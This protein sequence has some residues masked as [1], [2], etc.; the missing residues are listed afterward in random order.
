MTGIAHQIRATPGIARQA[1]GQVLPG[2]L[3]LRDGTP[4]LIWPLLPTD[5]GTLRDVFRRLSPDSRHQRFLQVL[6][7]LDDPM[8]WRLVDSVDGVHHIALLLI[9]L[10]PEGKEEP[11]GVARLV[12]HPE[13]PATADIAI[14]VADDWQR[15]GV[16]TALISALMERR[17]AAVTRLH[18]VIEAGNRGSLAL[19]ARTGQ[20][21]PGLPERGVLDV[22]V[23]LP[24][25]SQARTAAET[26]AWLWAQGTRKIIDQTH[27]LPWL[28]PTSLI[29]AVEGYVEF[30]QR[31]AA[32][33]GD[34]AV[35][36]AEAASAQF[37][38]VC[39]QVPH[40]AGRR[41]R[42]RAVQHPRPGRCA[43][44]TRP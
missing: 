4:V 1:P 22:T 20:M 37:G 23:E 19:L 24:P 27:L 35:K 32:I 28:P 42:P 38:V 6:D 18:T 7:Q 5:A 9:V 43:A 14:A 21:S 17:P 11:A 41:R 25:A 33:N 34:L 30:M 29:P 16:G 15:R 36:W 26:V 13:D 40:R 31:M 2:E 3:V 44:R 10:P 12:Q 8:I 39:A